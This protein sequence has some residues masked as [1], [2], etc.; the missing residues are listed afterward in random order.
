MNNNENEEPLLKALG[1]AVVLATLGFQARNNCDIPRR[2]RAIHPSGNTKLRDAIMEST[3]LL[4]SLGGALNQIGAGN[5]WN[6]VHIVLTDGDDTGSQ[7]SLQQVA[8][9]MGLIARQLNVEALKTWFIGVDLAAN[10]A[11][12]IE[13]RAVALAGKE[14]AEF[15]RVSTMEIGSIFE[16]I[17]I[18]LAEIRQTKVGLIADERAAVLAINQ[19]VDHIL[20]VKKQS[21]V[22]LFT[23]DISGSM[24]GGKWTQ[25]C[26]S[27]D[28]II[29][30]LG[31]EDVV[32]CVVFN[33]KIQNVLTMKENAPEPVRN[34]ANY[35]RNNL[36]N[37]PPVN[38]NKSIQKQFNVNINNGNQRVRRR[39]SDWPWYYFLPLV[40]L[41]FC[42]FL[43]VLVLIFI[44]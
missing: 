11:A 16:K 30:N 19:K 31:D 20:M 23:L 4:V 8:D 36:N 25:V 34:N 9:S 43:G 18:N 39:C 15:E 14:N 12:A 33:D 13:L 37:Q 6:I 41:L 42:V 35:N 1:A 24:A 3:N 44:L 32:G 38:N 28:S 10:S 22:V 27:V 40:I 2:I 21:F 5:I 7:T 29:D 26:Q 17:K